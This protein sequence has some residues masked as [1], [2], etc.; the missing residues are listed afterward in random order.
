MQ[1]RGKHAFSTIERLCFLLGPR[2]VAINDDLRQLRKKKKRK[3]VV[4][5]RV[6]IPPP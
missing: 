4:W 5:R 2:P 6:R 1:R 3:K